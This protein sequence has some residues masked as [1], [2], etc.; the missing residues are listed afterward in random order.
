MTLS[1]F[2]KSTCGVTSG[3]AHN[4]LLPSE[5]TFDEAKIYYDHKNHT[6]GLKTEVAV[7]AQHPY[8]CIHV[9]YHVP[10][11][12]HDFELFKNGFARYLDYLLKLLEE[13]IALPT[14]IGKIRFWPKLCLI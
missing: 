8:Y 11:S 7:S 5:S 1:P 13:H 14:L 12:V 2:G 6:H 9:S 10:A 4:S 3:C